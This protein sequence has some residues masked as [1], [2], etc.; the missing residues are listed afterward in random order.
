MGGPR[1]LISAPFSLTA[2]MMGA[3]ASQ[4]VIAVTDQNGIPDLDLA[5]VLIFAVVSISGI[6]QM[7]L[8]LFRLG[9][10]AKY[11]P[12]PVISGLRNG[13]AIAIIVAQAH[14]LLGLAQTEAINLDGVLWPTL[15]I[16]VFC[17]LVIAFSARLTTRLPGALLAIIAGTLVYYIISNLAG[18]DGLT[19]V[20]GDIPTTIPTP[21]LLDDFYN[22]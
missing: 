21:H 19:E 1:I 7:L 8:G 6:I 15:F 16:G 13:A 12:M 4:V 2:V 14:P 17:I 18:P 5:L 22:I 20:I 9:D 3:L 11:M 10:L